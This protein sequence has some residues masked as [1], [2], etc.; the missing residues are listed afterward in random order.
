[1]A[2]I[3]LWIYFQIGPCPREPSQ[4]P[5]RHMDGR[6]NRHGQDGRTRGLRQCN[7]RDI[8]LI[9]TQLSGARFAGTGLAKTRVADQAATIDSASTA[10]RVDFSSAP[11]RLTHFGIRTLS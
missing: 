2:V 6:D 3:G 5:P 7:S 10:E 1:M 9:R 8:N 11:F 4:R